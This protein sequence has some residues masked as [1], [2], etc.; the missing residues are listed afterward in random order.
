MKPIGGINPFT[1]HAREATATR[2]PFLSYLQSALCSPP[3]VRCSANRLPSS[4][5]P[6]SRLCR[7][8]TWTSIA[9]CQWVTGCWSR[10]TTPRSRSSR[11]QASWSK[12]GRPSPRRWTSAA[13]CWRCRPASTRSVTRRVAFELKLVLVTD[14]SGEYLVYCSIDLQNVPE[15]QGEIFARFV[16]ITFYKLIY[17]QSLTTHP[18]PLITIKTVTGLA[19]C[20]CLK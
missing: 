11:S 19:D 13:R 18:D 4:P 7:T 6:F 8:C 17:I 14:S 15:F 9:S 2:P 1:V 16:W 3:N 5:L 10:V 12:S 20:F